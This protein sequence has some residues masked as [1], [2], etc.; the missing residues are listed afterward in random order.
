MANEMPSPLPHTRSLSTASLSLLSTIKVG[1]LR[2]LAIL[3]IHSIPLLFLTLIMLVSPHSPANSFGIPQHHP[4][5]LRFIH[6]YPT[7]ATRPSPTFW[8]GPPR[9]TA[10]DWRWLLKESIA[11]SQSTRQPTGCSAK[12]YPVTRHKYHHRHRGRRPLGSLPDCELRLPLHI[13]GIHPRKK[14]QAT[15]SSQILE[16][17]ELQ[18]F[19]RWRRCG[20]CSSCCCWLR[21]CYGWVAQCGLLLDGIKL[22]TCDLEQYLFLGRSTVPHTFGGVWS[23]AFDCRTEMGG[24]RVAISSAWKT[25]HALCGI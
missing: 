20:S 4:L 16:F 5:W 15:S 14:A 1:K 19:R 11:E 24:H 10:P 25:E 13:P 21:Q 9:A 18:I 12:T 17:E 8:V 22:E 7:F 3:C 2:Y 23:H 6:V